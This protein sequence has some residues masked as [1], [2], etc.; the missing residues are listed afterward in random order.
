MDAGP[1]QGRGADVG[2]P[3]ASSGLGI[4]Q[5]AGEEVTRRGIGDG[6]GGEVEWLEWELER[7]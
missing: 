4:G 7:E 1:A 5:R 6:E 2:R 3:E